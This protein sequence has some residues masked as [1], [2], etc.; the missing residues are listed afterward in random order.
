MWLASWR[1]PSAKLVELNWNVHLLES[2]TSKARTALK[3]DSDAKEETLRIDCA[4][5]EVIY[6]L[7]KLRYK[8]GK[9]DP[10][11]FKAFFKSKGIPR[12]TFL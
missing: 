6:G 10:K 2:L 12:K 1:K 7:H 5:V 11:G 3:T 9:G 4:A 8:Q